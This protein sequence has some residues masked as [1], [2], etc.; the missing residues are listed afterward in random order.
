MSLKRLVRRIA[1][2]VLVALAP[3]SLSAQEKKLE[4]FEEKI[5][6]FAVGFKMVAI[7]G[8]SVEVKTAKD[9]PPAKVD[10]KPFYIC[11]HET[12]WE[13]FDIFYLAWD[14]PD[15][16]VRKETINAKVTRPSTPYSSP[17]HNFGHV[18]YPALSM[19]AK[20]A[21]VYC[22]WLSKKTGKKYRLPTEAEWV[23]A[24]QAGEGFK[25]LSPE[26]LQ[27]V[28]W[29][30]DNSQSDEHV[31]GK[32]Q[33]VKK[34]DPNKWGLFDMLGNAMELCIGL[35]GVPVAKGGSFKTG[36]KVLNSQLRNLQTPEWNDTDPNDPKSTWWLSD[37]KNI[38]FRVVCEP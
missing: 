7:P 34:K 19:S 4:T 11:E 1:P 5:P 9:Q 18:G 22:D 23:H 29:F 15:P 17:Q 31:D 35:D 6:G 12:R 33:P 37:G 10:V 25:Q 20:S 28:A 14:I 26:E 27:K 38:T 30:A 24:C 36:A 16:V 21:Q 3:L 13:E 8:G 32:T 2:V